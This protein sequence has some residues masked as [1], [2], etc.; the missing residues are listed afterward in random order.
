MNASTVAQPNPV[1]PA[2]AL[3]HCNKSKLRRNYLTNCQGEDISNYRIALW[4]AT[5]PIAAD[6]RERGVRR[7]HA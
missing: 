3:L 2:L 6:W 5:T 7:Y 4:R 1:P